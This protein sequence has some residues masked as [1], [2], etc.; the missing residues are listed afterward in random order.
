MIERSAVQANSTASVL[1][2]ISAEM[3]EWSLDDFTLERLPNFYPGKRLRTHLPNTVVV[4]RA[5]FTKYQWGGT[6]EYHRDAEAALKKATSPVKKQEIYA[7]VCDSERE[8]VATAI[9]L[10]LFSVQD[11]SKSLQ[12]LP[13]VAE[14]KLMTVRPEDIERLSSALKEWV[15]HHG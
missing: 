4:D 8:A 1:E 7:A 5:T 3:L 14:M 6:T 9:M 12:A 11:L 13:Q 10:E 2:T 15:S